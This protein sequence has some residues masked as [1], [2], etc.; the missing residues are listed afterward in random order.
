MSYHLQ[1]VIV[2]GSRRFEDRGL[3]RSA[4]LQAYDAVR[5]QNWNPHPDFVQFVVASEFG[6]DGVERPCPGVASLAVEI[7]RDARR[8]N[9]S[10][11]S[12]TRLLMPALHRLDW[13]NDSPF[14]TAPSRW[15]TSVFEDV[16]WEGNSSHNADSSWRRAPQFVVA[17]HGAK[18]D[19]LA[20]MTAKAGRRASAHVLE[21]AAGGVR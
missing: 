13:E 8:V 4:M 1:R 20:S 3:V 16:Y 9:R 11:D 19:G 12:D 2:V 10:S 21:F 5:S 17:V 6:K 14:S 7:L 15:V 18:I